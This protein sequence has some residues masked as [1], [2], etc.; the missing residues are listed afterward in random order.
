M[1]IP[2][3]GNTANEVLK[4][5]LNYECA[6]YLLKFHIVFAG[7]WQYNRL[8]NKFEKIKYPIIERTENDTFD[9]WLLNQ[10]SKG[11]VSIFVQ[12]PGKTHF[13]QRKYI[14]AR[15]NKYLYE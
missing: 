14:G 2:I 1:N 7:E 5:A 6:G 12:S 13:I 4:N 11:F 9:D 8:T 15:R 3:L 10:I